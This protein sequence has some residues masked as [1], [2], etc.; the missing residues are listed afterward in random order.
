MKTVLGLLAVMALLPHTFSL[1]SEQPA[2]G[3]F[4]VAT[5]AVDGSSFERTVI[6]L[7]HYDEAGAQGLVVN[8]RS[9]A[10]LAEVFPDSELLASY[11]GALFWG[12]PVRMTTMRALLQTDKPP[13]DAVEII[14]GVYQV[15]LDMSIDEFVAD[16][17]TLRFYIGYAGWAPGQLDRELS[18]GSWDVVAA[19]ADVVFAQNPDSIWRN[20]RP[21][22][23]FRAMNVASGHRRPE[24]ALQV[25]MHDGGAD[26]IAPHIGGRAETV[27]EP[28]DRQQ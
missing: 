6:L 1:A 20:V 18:F 28:V 22:P 10:N 5:D 26:R 3:K 21:I 19:S 16:A 7:L 27:Q 2:A 8:R 11:S 13:P 25:T 9:D 15:P 23:E 17:A 14:A 24:A 4:L 12:G